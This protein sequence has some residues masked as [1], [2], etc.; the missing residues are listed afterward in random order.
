MSPYR[1]MV[2]GTLDLANVATVH[3]KRYQSAFL[4]RIND[5]SHGTVAGGNIPTTPQASFIAT[6]RVSSPLPCPATD[7]AST[8]ALHLFPL[9]PFSCLPG[10]P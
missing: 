5:G 2:R 7:D 4:G 6:R 8:N 3:P 1:S 10:G 9:V